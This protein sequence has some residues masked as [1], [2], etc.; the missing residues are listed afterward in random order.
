MSKTYKSQ[1]K[2]DYS[3]SNSLSITFL[4]WVILLSQ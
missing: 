1:G 2:K 3:M 4:K